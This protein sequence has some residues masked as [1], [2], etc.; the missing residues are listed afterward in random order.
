[1][2]VAM[3]RLWGIISLTDTSIIKLQKMQIS[4]KLT[5][6]QSVC[7]RPGYSRSAENHTW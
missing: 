3:S 4:E 1:M 7:L 5:R 6:C 2:S